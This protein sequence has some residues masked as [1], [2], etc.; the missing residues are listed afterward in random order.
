[1]VTVTV[2]VP[3]APSYEVVLQA[4]EEAARS[5]R[6]V[7]ETNILLGILSMVLIYA[8]YRTGRYLVTVVKRARVT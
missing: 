4:Q 3:V 8:G 1:V 7:L 6:Q 5:Q 2:P